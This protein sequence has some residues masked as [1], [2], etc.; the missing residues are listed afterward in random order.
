MAL[1]SILTYN[2]L[3]HDLRYR[4]SFYGYSQIDGKLIPRIKLRR[5]IND[6]VAL[7]WEDRGQAI[8]VATMELDSSMEFTDKEIETMIR[9]EY[10]K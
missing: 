1:G 5:V 4:I 2:W 9:K 6:A 10:C 7:K 8:D 3:I